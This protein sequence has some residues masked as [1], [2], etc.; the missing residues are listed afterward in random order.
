[1]P[2]Y[3]ISGKS[4]SV[5]PSKA[6]RKPIIYLNT[7]EDEVVDVLKVIDSVDFPDFTLV[8]IC[9]LD[10]NHDMSLWETPPIS[11]NDAPCTGGADEYLKILTDGIIPTV[12]GDLEGSILWRGLVGYS[13]A[14]LFALYAPYRTGAFS[15]IASISGSL[16]FPGLTDFIMSND[17]KAA[18][19]K[20]YFSLGDK[21][22]KTHNQYLKTVQENT[23]QI[24]KFYRA[25]GIETCYQLNPGNHFMDVGGRIGAG[26]EWLLKK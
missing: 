6:P 16:W 1:M 9:R 17:M 15:R 13:L 3:N 5:Y 18:P 19:E 14:G 21:E 20:M 23:E 11:K 22:A 25:S 26:I 7:V 8:E 4:I 12:E 2:H 10:W 24:E